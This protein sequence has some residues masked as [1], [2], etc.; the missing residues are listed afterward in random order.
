MATITLDYDVHSAQAKKALDFILSLGIFRT[1][2]RVIVKEESPL[3][4][5]K[6]LDKALDNYLI[7][8]SGYKFDRNDANDYE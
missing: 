7:D 8:L 2:E 1:S 4:K 3:N 5:R 6:E